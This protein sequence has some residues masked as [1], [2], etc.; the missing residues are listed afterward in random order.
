MA[1]LMDWFSSSIWKRIDITG[2]RTFGIHHQNVTG[3]RDAFNSL[4]YFGE[5]S[6][7]FTDTGQMTLVGN[8][9]LGFFNFNMTLTDDRFSDPQS[10]RI[11]MAYEKSGFQLGYGDLTSVSLLN[12]NDFARYTKTLSGATFGYNKGRFAFKA[13]RTETKSAART[14]SIQG[15]NTV[16]PY[17]IG[18]SQIVTDSEEIR[19]DG[20]TMKQ[21]QDYTI[22]YQSGSF[23][24]ISRMIAPTSTIV[25]SYETLG[26]NTTPGTVQGAGLS[27]D[28]G[29]AGRIGFT[30]LQQKSGGSSGLSSRTEKW[31]GQGPPTSPYFLEFDPLPSRPIVVKVNGILQILGADYIFGTDN[32]GA[33]IYTIIYF[34]RPIPTDQE[35]EFTYTPKPVQTIDGDRSVYGF[36]YKL[37]L[38]SKGFL[39]YSQATG[40]L[41][42]GITPM[43]GTARGIKGEYSFGPYHVHAGIRDVPATF[44]SVESRSFNRNEKATDFGLEYKKKAYT[45]GVTATNSDIITQSVD[46]NNNVVFNGSKY[47]T[48]GAY[49]NYQPQGTKGI[50]W[51]LQHNRTQSSYTGYDS[52]IDTTTL[53]ANK[54]FGRL[55]TR[56]S[57]DHENGF[58]PITLSDGVTTKDGAVSLDAIRL[59]ADYTTSKGWFFGTR[60]SLSRMNSLGKSGNGNDITLSTSYK[61]IK[62]PF[63]FE[64]SYVNSNSG[65]LSS[66][67]SFQNGSGIGYGGNGFT[68]STA[69]STVL[70]GGSN[71]KSFSVTPNYKINSRASLN[72]RFYQLRQSGSFNS[73]SETMSYGLGV[74]WDLGGNTLVSTNVD[75]SAT[76]FLDLTARTESTAVELALMGN[77]KGPWSYR[78]GLNSLISGKTTDYA[79]DS[80]G[81]DGYLR[82]RLNARSNLSLQFTLGRTSGYL[83]QSEHFIGAFYEYQLYRNVALVGSYKIRHVLNNDP[84]ITTG[85]YRSSGFDLELNFNFGS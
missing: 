48:Q 23:T 21:G 74:N 56:L 57:L 53:A 58:G 59:N 39:S 26:F 63:D 11:W 41:D 73:N 62:G 66:L 32:S 81:I 45:W 44:V 70:N 17:Y 50:T 14:R 49:L 64:A 54:T 28:F 84:T 29:K 3:D 25:I 8:K 76:R 78:I 27:Y 80:F 7:M 30:A 40:K 55:N 20:T 22:N 9:V 61:P 75:R 37:P 18:D 83:P 51:S 35:V 60:T 52:K 4:N 77:P 43:Q 42:N 38:G 19:V 33:P 65:S 36:D 69:T 5:G 68:G 31:E 16:G 79:Q 72:G 85:A 12:T 2:R 71:Y 24:F 10:K 34:L 15:T 47:A 1:P 13:V 82:H 67:G 6:K 46:A